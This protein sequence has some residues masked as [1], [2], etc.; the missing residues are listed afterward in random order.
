MSFG[1]GASTLLKP[2]NFTGSPTLVPPAAAIQ[3]N[4]DLYRKRIILTEDIRGLGF[5]GEELKT[6]NTTAYKVIQEGK[7]ILADPD[8]LFRFTAS[9]GSV[10]ERTD[11][12]LED[13]KRKRAFVDKYRKIANSYLELGRRSLGPTLELCVPVSNLDIAN[14]LLRKTKLRIDPEQIR[15][16][17]KGQNYI[18]RTGHSHVYVDLPGGA[19]TMSVVCHDRYAK[20]RMIIRR[21]PGHMVMW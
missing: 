2:A 13:L 20:L 18:H 17:Q 19:G 16:P 21:M 1:F 3:E 15:F 9:D 14:S 11:E 10:I 12:M 6:N 8:S 7:A 5:L 4:L